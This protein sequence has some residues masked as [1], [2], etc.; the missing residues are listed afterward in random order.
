[1]L[2]SVDL[3]ARELHIKLGYGANIYKHNNCAP[4]K[5]REIFSV[6]NSKLLEIRKY[7]YKVH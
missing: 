3:I 5:V 1:M 4:F 6:F 7:I 2:K